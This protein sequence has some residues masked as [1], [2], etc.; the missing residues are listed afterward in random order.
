MS[1]HYLPKR[2]EAMAAGTEESVA[3]EG[4]GSAA[5]VWV[6][7]TEKADCKHQHQDTAALSIMPPDG[8]QRAQQSKS[9][10]ARFRQRP[11]PLDPSR[12]A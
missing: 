5:A 6:E 9:C 3:R 7:A 11:A 1:V 4:G 12:I 8:T 2:K 10:S